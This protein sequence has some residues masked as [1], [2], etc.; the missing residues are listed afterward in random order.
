MATNI[1]QYNGTL[2]V[3]LADGTLD[4]V[5]SPLALPGKGYTNYGEPVL[6]DILWTMTNFAGSTA[7]TPALD[8][9]CWYDSNTNKLKVYSNSA[10]HALFSDN[11]DNIPDIDGN[12][13]LGSSTRR[14]N[15]VYALEMQADAFV[16]DPT[17]FRDNKDNLPSVDQTYDMGATNYRFSAVYANVF[18]GVAT[19]AR[20]ADLAERYETDTPVEPGDLVSLAGEKEITKTRIQN[21]PEYFGVIST[22]PAFK[23]NSDAGDDA[24]HPYVALAGRVPCKV[25]GEIRKGQRLAVSNIPGVACGIGHPQALLPV[26]GRALVDKHTSEI[27]LIEIVV[28]RW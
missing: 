1:Y 18:D 15:T 3:T 14:F 25:V 11:V 2:L 6:Q 22:D 17:I 24:T 4:T 9:M 10:Y 5:A 16:G 26:V 12:R 21:D 27:E 13:D 8:G 20:Y 23:M 28:G 19:Q 7:P